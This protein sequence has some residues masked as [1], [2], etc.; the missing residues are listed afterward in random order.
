MK[1]LLPLLMLSACSSL[2][3]AWEGDCDYGDDEIQV[4]LELIQDGDDIEGIG[5]ISYL[6]GNVLETVALEIDGKQ[7]RDEIDLE[8]EMLKLGTMEI[9]GILEDKDTISGECVWS[10]EDVWNGEGVF[11]LG[12]DD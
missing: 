4:E 10:G 6:I 3:A 12:R 11:D 1:S 5:T 8:L 7:D 2:T 9:R